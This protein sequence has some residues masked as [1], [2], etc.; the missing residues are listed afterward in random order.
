MPLL[1]RH[2][3][4]SKLISI[5]MK[6]LNQSANFCCLIQTFHLCGD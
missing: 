3:V 1:Y 4:A 6:S 5:K 2:D